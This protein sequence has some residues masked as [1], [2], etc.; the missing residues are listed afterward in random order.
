MVTW[1]DGESSDE[2]FTDVSPSIFYLFAFVVPR[3]P[4]AVPRLRIGVFLWRFDRPAEIHDKNFCGVV[5]E[6]M[7]LCRIHKE[8]AIQCV[9]FEGINTGR[10]FYR[11]PCRVVSFVLYGY[12][13]TTL[14]KFMFLCE[15]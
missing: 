15:S 11:F 13:F 8:P 14:V 12:L 1:I 2:D 6:S 5:A 10:H 7:Y 4:F 3:F 9:A